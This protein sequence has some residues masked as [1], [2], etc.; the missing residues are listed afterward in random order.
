MKSFYWLLLLLLICACQT[1]QE[2][3]E[4]AGINS[5]IPT[6]GQI[7]STADST[8]DT[9]I[10]QQMFELED[11]LII[12]FQGC[13]FNTKCY[14]FI[15][16]HPVEQYSLCGNKALP[17]DYPYDIDSPICEDKSDDLSCRADAIV[18]EDGTM[19]LT[20]AI[21]TKE[22]CIFFDGNYEYEVSNCLNYDQRLLKC[23]FDQQK[24]DLYWQKL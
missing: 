11:D 20:N 18:R 10:F 17:G 5:P 7:N 23:G 4:K 19:T 2:A 1:Q 21:G 14:V 24:Y 12:N 16:V 9:R 3:V 13:E 8:P 6:G 22:E 15:E